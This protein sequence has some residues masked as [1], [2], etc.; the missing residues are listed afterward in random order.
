MRTFL[1]VLLV[2]LGSMGYAQTINAKFK[3][4]SFDELLIQAKAEA[5]YKAQQK[6]NFQRYCDT[7]YKYW[8]NKDYEGFIYYSDFALGTGF[9]SNSLYYDRGRAY[10]YLRNYKKAKK[11]YKKAKRNGYYPAVSALE[12]CV[13][14]E[15]NWK[16]MNKK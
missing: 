6:E 10:E 14:N 9:S 5:A 12:Q 8:K 4:L 7:A 1:F 13:A 15:K 2:S 16:K 3:P 11:E